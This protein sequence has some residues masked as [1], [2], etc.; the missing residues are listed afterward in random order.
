MELVWLV[1]S[2]QPARAT[3][4]CRGLSDAVSLEK[5]SASRWTLRD[6]QD[7]MPVHADQSELA[8]DINLPSMAGS[9]QVSGREIIFT[10][11]FPLQ[12]GVCY[13]AV[14]RPSALSEGKST[15]EILTAIHRMDETALSPSTVITAV[16][17][18]AETLPEN[19]LK[20]Y[21]HFSSPMSGGG[22]HRHIRLRD[23]GGRIVTQPFL[24]I[25]QEMWNHAM[26]RLTLFIDPGRIK[27]GLAPRADLGPVLLQGQR[28]TLEIDESWQDARGQP[29]KSGFQKTFLTGQPDQRSPIPGRWLLKVPAKGGREPLHVHF[30]EPLD[31]ALA[32]RLLRIAGPDAA[33]EG[34]SDLTDRGRSWHFIPSHAWKAGLHHV[35]VPDILE[36]LAG[37]SV[38]KPFEVDLFTSAQP[39]DRIKTLR[40]PFLIQ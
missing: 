31:H 28:F 22:S 18:D 9:Y 25:D 1:D 15:G 16:L 27:Q 11:L 14:F 4:H 19:T 10:P 24:E 21:L 5:L 23:A 8:I 12:T 30:D 20:F 33:V 7:L 38:G 39:P 3:V 32:L 40:L 6:W 13:R 2:A 37:N 29:L 17:P 26:T 36:D 35:E 34:V